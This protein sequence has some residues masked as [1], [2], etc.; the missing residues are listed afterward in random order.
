MVDRLAAA[1]RAGRRTRRRRRPRRGLRHQHVVGDGLAQRL[2]QIVDGQRRTPRPAGRGA[3]AAPRPT[4]S[5]APAGCRA[6]GRSTRATRTSARPCGSPSEQADTSSSAKKALP[7]LRRAALRSIGS[8]RLPSASSR[9]ELERLAGIERRQLDPFD[10]GQPHQLRQHRAQGVAAV[11]FVGAVGGQHAPA[12][13]RRAARAGRPAGRGWTGRPS[14]GP[15]PPAVPAWSAA[16]SSSDGQNGVEHPQLAEIAVLAGLLPAREPAGE[17][18]PQRGVPGDQLGLRGRQR[19]HDL[20]EGQ[21]GQRRLGGVQAPPEQHGEARRRGPLD[22]LGDQPGLADAGVARQQTPVGVP[23]AARS[24]AAVRREHLAP[25]PDQ[26]DP[27]PQPR[28]ASHR[29]TAYRLPVSTTARRAKPGSGGGRSGGPPRQPGEPEVLGVGE[30]RAVALAGL[31][32]GERHV[33]EHVVESR[34][35]AAHPASDDH[36]GSEGHR[37]RAG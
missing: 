2:F 24:N 34:P 8:D 14:A 11:Q 37:G 33:G 13:A 36:V 17:Q 21:V 9:D 23:A 32:G 5:A 15:P 30:E 12:A 20:G 4:R 22:G 1:A 19:T 18:V 10:R 25:A 27:D 6:A 29:G 7:S 31:G 26:P 35:E 28:H 16:S 3:P